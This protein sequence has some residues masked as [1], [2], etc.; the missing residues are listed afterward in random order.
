MNKRLLDIASLVNNSYSMADIGTD[1]GYLPIYLIK[2]NI[3]K[4]AYASDVAI[5]PLNKA[6]ENI[7]D[8]NLIDKVIPLLANGL[9]LIP[10]DVNQIVIAGMGGDLIVD[11]LSKAKYQYDTLILQ[12]NLHA[13]KVRSYLI[14]NNYM[15][16]DELVSYDNKKYYDIIKAIKG[17]QEL[18]N[19]EIKYGPINLINKKDIFIDKLHSIKKSYLNI[20]DSFKGSNEEKTRIT[21]ELNELNNILGE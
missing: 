20:L 18:S 9:D 11:I 14:N 8:N 17:K 1:H 21:K 6:K 7:I 5:G 3:V 10:S 4:L 13:E 2:N 19:I 12:P 16:V 15:I